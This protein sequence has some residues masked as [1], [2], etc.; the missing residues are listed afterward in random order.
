MGADNL[1]MTLHVYE[2]AVTLNVH[3]RT[4]VAPAEKKIGQ[5]VYI[6][7]PYNYAFLTSSVAVVLKIII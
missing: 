6:M 3:G 7:Y 4:L 1:R 5:V 2:Y